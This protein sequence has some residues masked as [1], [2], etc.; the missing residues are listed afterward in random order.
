SYAPLS[1]NLKAWLGLMG[2]VLPLL[3][4]FRQ[5]PKENSQDL[6][7]QKD[8]FTLRPWHWALL[9]LA[10][11][12]LRFHGITALPVWPMWDDA[13]CAFD[14]LRLMDH[15]SWDPSYG[16]IKLPSLFFWFEAL[17]FKAAGPS[18]FTLFLFPALLSAIGLGLGYW[19]ARR[20]FS[21]SLAF[22]FTAFLAFGFW[23]LF[24]G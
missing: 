6:G 18:L 19:M 12:A 24:M 4:A 13:D 3:L 14:S 11:L 7:F 20:L 16:Q 22:L 5:P 1:F 21:P 10:G 2:V 8:A 15:W 9:L 17:F 23:P